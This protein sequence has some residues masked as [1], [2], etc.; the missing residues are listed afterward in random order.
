MI[1]LERD[2]AFWV[3]VASH[4]AVAQALAGMAPAAVASIVARD[5]VLPL[6]A[7]HGGYLFR[8]LDPLGH[9]CELHSLFTPDGWGREALTA[10]LQAINAVWIA[11]YQLVTTHQVRANP[12][13]QPPRTFAFTPAGDWR[14]SPIGDVR[15]WTLSRLAWE[16]SPAARRHLSH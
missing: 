11:G 1:R 13:S 7:E 14:P 4:P 3:G 8:R 6:A 16:S 15:L 2:P 10:G 9:I 5:D 12:R